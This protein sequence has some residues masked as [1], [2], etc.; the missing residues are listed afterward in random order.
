MYSCSLY[1]CFYIY[2]TPLRFDIA[3]Q[4]NLDQK[5]KDQNGLLEAI[6]SEL[7]CDDKW[8][9]NIPMER[10]L[11]KK[12]EPRYLFNRNAFSEYRQKEEF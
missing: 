8:N 12:G 4:C 3:A 7:T 5:D 6:L 9:M 11:K 2:L 10:A 1:F